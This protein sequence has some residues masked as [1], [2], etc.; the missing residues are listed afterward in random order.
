[1]LSLARQCWRWHGK[2]LLIWVLLAL[3]LARQSW[4]WHGKH[5]CVGFAGAVA[6]TATLALAG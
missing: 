3:S 5:S 1:M 6:G 4:R 2:E